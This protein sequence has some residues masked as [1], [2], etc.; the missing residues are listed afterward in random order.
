M[1]EL[2][3]YIQDMAD[4]FWIVNNITDGIA[5]GYMVYRVCENGN[6]FNHLTNKNYIKDNDN[7]GIIEIPKNYKRLFK[8]RKF[9]EDNKSNLNSIWKDYIDVLNEI[10]IADNDI[11][12]FGSYLVG[13]DITKDVDFAIYKRENLYKYYENIEYIKRKLNVTSISLEHA[14]YQYNKHKEK[15]PSQCDL[16]EIVKRNWSG[17]QLA[18]GVLSTPRFI[19]LNNMSIPK[20]NG[21][22]KVVTV[23]VLEGIETAMLPRLAKVMY[24]E[25]EYQ[26]LSTI[27]KFQS[28]AHTEDI[29]EIYGNINE[30][31][32]TIILDDTNYY[33]KYLKKS[34]KI[35]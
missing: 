17:I 2:L 12:I 13:F 32:K 4:N 28:F 1:I 6:K 10:G 20:K 35:I 22:D 31:E 14:D 27:W 3:D 7:L 9:Y 18:N 34:E 21:E 24:K 8:P 33:I 5:K 25:E 11:G 30:K 29:L 19:D 16:K 26:V 15:F 23:T